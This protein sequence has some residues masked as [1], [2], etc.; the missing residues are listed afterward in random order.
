MSALGHLGLLVMKIGF[1][2]WLIWELFNLVDMGTLI[3]IHL[4]WGKIEKKKA[5][6]GEPVQIF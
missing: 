1:L 6:T 2:I 5:F 4:E 3:S